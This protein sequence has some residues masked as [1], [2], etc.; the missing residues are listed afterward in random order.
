MRSG[1]PRLRVEIWRTGSMEWQWNM[2]FY[3]DYVPT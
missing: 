2:I 3:K 1:Q